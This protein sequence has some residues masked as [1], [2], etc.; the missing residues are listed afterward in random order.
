MNLKNMNGK[1]IGVEELV[2]Q[3]N[4]EIGAVDGSGISLAMQQNF[5]KKGNLY[6]PLSMNLGFT[7]NSERGD[8]RDVTTT[9]IANPLFYQ[10][11]KAVALE[12]GY[13]NNHIT[14]LNEAPFSYE[15]GPAEINSGSIK[16]LLEVHKESFIKQHEM[17]GNSLKHSHG[18]EDAFGFFTD[19]IP[20]SELVRFEESLKENLDQVS[21]N[22][23]VPSNY[24]IVKDIADTVSSIR[25]VEG[26]EEKGNIYNNIFASGTM[27][28]RKTLAD[29]MRTMDQ[30][31]KK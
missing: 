16:D 1:N 20:Y 27:P 25:V 29:T 13:V 12:D 2:D 14:T 22:G 19:S 23:R 18:R 4:S 17:I 7:E 9:T 21:V 6:L 24:S 5:E 30:M 8:K 26:S 3:L 10:T 15:S 11:G 28:L 31:Y